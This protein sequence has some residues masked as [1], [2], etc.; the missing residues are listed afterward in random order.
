MDIQ[1]KYVFDAFPDNPG[2]PGANAVKNLK[3]SLQDVLKTGRPHQMP[4]QRYD[5][6]KSG[7]QRTYFEEKYWNPINT[8]VLDEKGRVLC[9]IHKVSD[10]TKVINSERQ[11]ED[12]KEETDAL[13]GDL[14]E[15]NKELKAVTL[16]L[17]ES[18]QQLALRT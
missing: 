3:A 12:L 11:L 10:V 7:P 9:I 14:A 4:L 18:N 15:S 17:K 5:V 8:P 1:S 13:V 2:V 6:P 16:Q